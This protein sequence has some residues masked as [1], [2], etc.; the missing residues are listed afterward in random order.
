MNEKL[1]CR[2][3][4]GKEEEEDKLRTGKK[5]REREEDYYLSSPLPPPPQSRTHMLLS[6]TVD[7][8]IQLQ[9]H[10]CNYMDHGKMQNEHSRSTQSVEYEYLCR[11]WTP[12][13]SALS[14]SMFIVSCSPA[15]SLGNVNINSDYT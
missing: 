9:L 15:G 3:K 4:E 10:T 11:V 1:E 8:F 7:S 14:A 6:D 2:M 5:G 12:R 13:P